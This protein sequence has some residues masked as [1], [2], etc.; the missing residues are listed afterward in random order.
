MLIIFLIVL[1]VKRS[2][3]HSKIAAFAFPVEELTLFDTC[4]HVVGCLGPSIF[5]SIGLGLMSRIARGPM[6]EDGMRTEQRR[7]K[8]LI[9]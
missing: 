3:S 8:N 6:D 5:T 4:C 7:C 1:S 2:I 9:V